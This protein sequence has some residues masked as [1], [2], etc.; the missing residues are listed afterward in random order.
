MTRAPSL[1]QRPRSCA[2][3]CA[4]VMICMPLPP[5]SASQWGSGTGQ[6]WVTSSRAMSSG[7]SRRPP[8]IRL[9]VSAAWCL[10][11]STGE[12]GEQRRE[13]AS[14]VSDSAIR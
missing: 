2:S 8:G 3:P 9:P 12:G 14:S 11:T 10:C 6:I 5:E 7:G 13:R 4:I 1:L